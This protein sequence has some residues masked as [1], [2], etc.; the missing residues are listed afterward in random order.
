MSVILGDVLPSSD[1][2]LGVIVSGMEP[3]PPPRV[4]L[5]F[6]LYRFLNY[7]KQF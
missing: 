1:L 6:G 2:F 7:N 5:F 4:L 3:E